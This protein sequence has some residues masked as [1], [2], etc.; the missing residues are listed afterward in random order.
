MTDRH[1]SFRALHRPGDPFVLPNAWDRGTARMFEASGA[2]AIA[3]TSAGH[4]F[5]QGRVDG[6]TLTRDEAL[7]HVQDLVSAVRIP[8]SGDFENGFGEAPEQVAETIRLAAEVGLSGCSIEDT[9]LPEFTPYEARLSVERIRAGAAAARALPHDFVL[10]ARADGVMLGQYDLDEAIRRIRAYE[11]AGADCVY[12]PG[13]PD[14][15]AAR[16]VIESVGVPVNILASGPFSALTQADFACL[17]AA[18]LSTGGALA[19]VA[20]GAAIAAV[21]RMLGGDFTDLSRAAAEDDINA[22]LT[23]NGGS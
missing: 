15:A 5:S 12:V 17:G 10:V 18:R 4:S 7:A 9:A 19:R 6:G 22:L 16:R 13:L 8:V 21:R 14:G 2:A 3:T 23:R 1:A 11:E 20:Y